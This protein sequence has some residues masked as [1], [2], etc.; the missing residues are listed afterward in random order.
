MEMWKQRES[1]Q[2]TSK[3]LQYDYEKQAWVRNGKYI[4]CGHVSDCNCYG[5]LHAGEAPVSF[6]WI[7]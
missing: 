7:K 1:G 4:K 5:K 6:N 2:K 3:N